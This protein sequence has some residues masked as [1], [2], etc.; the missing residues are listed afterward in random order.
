M[1][2]PY[3]WNVIIFH[4]TNQNQKSSDDYYSKKSITSNLQS[5]YFGQNKK[6][7]D[8]TIKIWNMHEHFVIWFPV[9]LCTA[10]KTHFHLIYF[11]FTKFLITNVCMIIWRIPYK[12][13]WSSHYVTV[14]SINLYLAYIKLSLC[15][16]WLS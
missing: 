1:Y 14:C 4:L 3:S 11:M 13:L 2:F 5:S 8:G 16:S 12:N 7:L 10:I 15:F 9:L 6:L